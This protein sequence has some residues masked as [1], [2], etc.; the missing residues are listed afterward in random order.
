[1][2]F[3]KVKL[4]SCAGV[5]TC[6]CESW[7]GGLGALPSSPT[8]RMSGSTAARSRGSLAEGLVFPSIRS[9]EPGHRLLACRGPGLFLFGH[10]DES[11]LKIHFRDSLC[12]TAR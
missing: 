12:G 2:F 6:A 8:P 1:M 3:I 9:S 7:G 10:A 11:N 4:H 5:V